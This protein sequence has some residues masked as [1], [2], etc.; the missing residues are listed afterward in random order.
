MRYK[1]QEAPASLSLHKIRNISGEKNT[2]NIYKLYIMNSIIYSLNTIFM[3]LS[4][5]L[6]WEIQ[7]WWW[8]CILFKNK[9]KK[10]TI[11]VNTWEVS[12]ARC[13]HFSLYTIAYFFLP[14][15]QLCLIVSKRLFSK[16]LSFCLVS[17]V[18][19]MQFWSRT[20]LSVQL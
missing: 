13:K 14:F 4:W 12:I 5:G 18:L 8:C 15:I 11:R 20:S 2:L 3:Q 6:H 17:S 9:T 19:F 7:V 10:I 1:C 16:Y